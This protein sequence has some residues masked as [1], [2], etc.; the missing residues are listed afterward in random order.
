MPNASKRRSYEK[1]RL[2]NKR[3]FFVNYSLLFSLSGS[4]GA[5]LFLAN[6]ARFTNFSLHFFFAFVLRF[7]CFCM[8]VLC[9]IDGFY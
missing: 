4:F 9:K 7:V 3:S 5:S 8:S 2:A 6:S 1:I